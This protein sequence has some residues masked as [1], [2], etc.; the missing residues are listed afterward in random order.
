MLKCS[1]CESELN[2]E[3]G[4]FCEVCGWDLEGDLALVPMLNRPSEEDIAK[5]RRKLE[6]AKKHWNK[7]L[8]EAVPKP[9][10]VESTNHHE[11]IKYLNEEACDE[12]TYS[13]F[14]GDIVDGKAHGYGELREIYKDSNGESE[15]QY[16]GQFFCGKR[17]G[18]GKLLSNYSKEHK[19]FSGGK[20]T[21]E[22]NFFEG[23]LHGEGKWVHKYADGG[24]GIQEGNF[25]EGTLQGKGKSISKY[26]DGT[27]FIYEGNFFEGQ[28]HGEGK[29]V[30]K[31]AD[32]T[33]R[34]EEGNFIGGKYQDK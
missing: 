19:Y 28:L 14:R 22:G 4:E 1:V 12:T 20:I 6:N 29:S 10:L 23:R 17:Q 33:E 27:E 24:E 13:Y 15:D 32:G 26:A 21:E 16:Q 11:I 3:F 18:E 7:K 2:E 5:Y 31:Y 34:K 8:E 9:I 30:W 25:F